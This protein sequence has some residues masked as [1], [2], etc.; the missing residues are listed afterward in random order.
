[1]K[2]NE[3]K[4]AVVTVGGGAKYRIR[5]DLL[6]EIL[7]LIEYLLIR[8]SYPDNLRPSC[9]LWSIKQLR[10]LDLT[11]SSTPAIQVAETSLS[12]RKS[13]NKF[14]KETW[15]LGAI[16]LDYKYDVASMPFEPGGENIHIFVMGC[17]SLGKS[18]MISIFSIKSSTCGD[19]QLI[20]TASEYRFVAIDDPCIFQHTE[21]T[22]HLCYSA[23]NK[24]SP[25][26]KALQ[27]LFGQL[28]LLADY[29]QGVAGRA[30]F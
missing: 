23:L 7:S 12:L 13:L 1:M 15:D 17:S 20:E 2:S 27:L 9:T 3:R 29:C 16:V 21:G 28:S 26:M 19:F 4:A 24:K 22:C 5:G 10:D 14:R 30:W 6:R 25:T 11:W 18:T 8:R